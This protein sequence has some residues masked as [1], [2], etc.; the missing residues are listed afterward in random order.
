MS[1]SVVAAK[2]FLIKNN[3]KNNKAIAFH[4]LFS[5]L[6][7]GTPLSTLKTFLQNIP[8][9]WASPLLV[10]LTPLDNIITYSELEAVF[11]KQTLEEN[12]RDKENSFFSLEKF[13]K[14]FSS[15]EKKN[16]LKA[17]QNNNVERALVY[18]EKLHNTDKLS[19]S[20]WEKIA[21]ERLEFE[22]IC[23]NIFLEFCKKDT[24]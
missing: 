1:I 5:V 18:F 11:V 2:D 14:F 19:L 6:Q 12:I 8:D 13:R 23:K 20:F 7:T 21:R 16:I 22:T 24:L 4:L 10:S 9:P 15:D 17:L 3:I